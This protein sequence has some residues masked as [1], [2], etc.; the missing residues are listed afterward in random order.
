MLKKGTDLLEENDA[1]PSFQVFF[2]SCRKFPT[3][4]VKEKH[5]GEGT[6][7]K[8]IPSSRAHRL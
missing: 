8:S 7:R 1:P 2:P 4:D 6:A 5:L 3:A